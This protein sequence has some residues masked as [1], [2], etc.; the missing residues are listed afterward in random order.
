[1]QCYLIFDFKILDQITYILIV[2]STLYNI[3]YKLKKNRSSVLLVQETFKE[4]DIFPLL[5]FLR[6]DFK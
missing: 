6:F 5:D 4:A 3:T 1:M 2:E